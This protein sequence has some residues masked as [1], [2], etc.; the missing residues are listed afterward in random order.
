M[1]TQLAVD[2]LCGALQ[3][4]P[5]D[6][7]QWRKKAKVI[8]DFAENVSREVLKRAGFA[9]SSPQNDA[10]LSNLLTQTV[11][12]VPDGAPQDAFAELFLC[13]VR[14]TLTSKD[15]EAAQN[16]ECT[17]LFGNGR[18]MI[19]NGSKVQSVLN[20]EETARFVIFWLAEKILQI[21]RKNKWDRISQLPDL[22]DRLA[23]FFTA[24]LKPVLP[25]GAELKDRL[26]LDYNPEVLLKKVVTYD[27]DDKGFQVSLRAYK[28]LRTADLDRIGEMVQKSEKQIGFVRNCSKRTV[29]ELRTLL[30]GLGLRFGMILPDEVLAWYRARL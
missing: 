16:P 23:S 7:E 1:K 28:A 20:Y 15:N 21:I 5:Q 3:N 9:D 26:G 6:E 30:D 17:L 19:L 18:A 4:E 11:D 25:S 22:F 8:C 2:A 12:D 24:Q 29:K 10:W 27:F 14:A 13:S